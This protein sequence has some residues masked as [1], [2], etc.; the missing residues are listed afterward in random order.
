MAVIFYVPFFVSVIFLTQHMNAFKY[1]WLE[2]I[3]TRMFPSTSRRFKTAR[4]NSLGAFPMFACC[5]SCILQELSGFTGIPNTTLISIHRQLVCLR[6]C[7]GRQRGKHHHRASKTRRLCLYPIVR[8]LRHKLFHPR[9][10]DAVICFYVRRACS[11]APTCVTE[12][13]LHL[14]HPGTVAHLHCELPP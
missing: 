3:R 13:H 14:H 12:T 1:P 8:G 11:C 5:F 9:I 7:K 6:M 10:I 2:N 4:R